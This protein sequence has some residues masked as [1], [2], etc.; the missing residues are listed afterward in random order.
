MKSIALIPARYEATRF[1]GK[2]M[3]QLG[4][5]TVIMH[6]FENT[7]KTMLFDEVIVAT[8]SKIIFDEIT[9]KGGYAILSDRNYETGSDR[10]AAAVKNI[11]VDVV[12]NVQGDEPFVNKKALED[13]LDVFNDQRVTAASLMCPIF[14]PAEIINPNYVKVVTDKNNNALYFSRS[15]IPFERNKAGVPVM[16]HVGI[17]GYRKNTLLHFCQ[18]EKTP[19]ESTEM[20]E[21]LR[22][23][24]NGIPIRMVETNLSPLSIDT[25]EDLEKARAYLVLNYSAK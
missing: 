24:E 5:K 2:L 10:I 7:K 3:Q 20:L 9:S 25:P 21:Q 13:L 23:L 18:L 12:I 11:D 4:E 8:D 6:T 15:P 17:Y 22:L 16:K 19:L 1:P 14:S